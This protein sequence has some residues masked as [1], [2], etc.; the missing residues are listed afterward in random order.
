MSMHHVVSDGWSGRLLQHEVRA[1]YQAFR[2][3]RPD[4]LPPL[5]VQYADFA[6]WQR[7]WLVGDVLDGQL[8]YWR[9][10]LAGAPVL[11]LPTDRPRPPVRSADGAVGGFTIAAATARGLRAVARDAGA[12]MFMTLLAGLDV[13]LARYGRV[14]DVS[15]GTPVANRNR[16][17]TE[18]LIGFFVNTVV[19]RTDLSGD[20][21][22]AEL[23]GRVRQT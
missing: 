3:G 8:A 22:F 1:L 17:E 21:S 7:R 20:P 12:S 16:V 19:L 5:P 9:E 6:V 4:P 11:E 2:A 23:V 13:L 10:Q 18:A 15:V 14:E